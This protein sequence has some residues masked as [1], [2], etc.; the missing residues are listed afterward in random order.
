MICAGI[1]PSLGRRSFSL[2]PALQANTPA[3]VLHR[4]DARERR[5][6]KTRQTGV[7]ESRVVPVFVSAP[8]FRSILKMTVTPLS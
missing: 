7:G 1:I 4:V 8:V 6:T 2:V 5:Y 3:M